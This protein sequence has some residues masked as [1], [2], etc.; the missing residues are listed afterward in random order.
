MVKKENPICQFAEGDENLEQETAVSLTF[1]LS[2]ILAT[3]P[4]LSLP[5]PKEPR[6]NTF[7]HERAHLVSPLSEMS[8][9]HK[10]SQ[11]DSIERDLTARN[12]SR[13][14]NRLHVCQTG[15]RWSLKFLTTQKNNS[16]IN[17]KFKTST[18]CNEAVRPA[19]SFR[20]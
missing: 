10:E 15:R 3:E 5:Y 18:E 8:L 6:F 11:E 19:P 12:T 17:Q 7:S 13:R 1:P 16:S 2:Q 4:K 9:L 14:E 20:S